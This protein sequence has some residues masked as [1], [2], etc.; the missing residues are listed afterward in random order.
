MLLGTKQKL[1]EQ[2]VLCF[3]AAPFLRAAD[4]Y[5]RLGGARTPTQ[6]A[7]FKELAKLVEQGVLVR[8]RG[9]YA[10]KVTWILEL[11]QLGEELTQHALPTESRPSDSE[12]SAYAGAFQ[13]YGGWTAFGFS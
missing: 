9:R 8:V 3:R 4:L 13:T 6:R 1:A 10:V 2:I 7:L 11:L 12:G 5:A